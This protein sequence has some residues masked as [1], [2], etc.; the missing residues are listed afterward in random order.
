MIIALS[1]VT[2][3]KNGGLHHTSLP[4]LSMFNQLRH[5]SRAS[6]RRLLN[7]DKLA[8]A[9]LDVLLNCE[10]MKP[11][12]RYIQCCSYY[13]CTISINITWQHL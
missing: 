6:K 2:C 8:T 1:G 4:M 9:L 7:D 5:P 13:I 12:I 3:N 10:E 11:F